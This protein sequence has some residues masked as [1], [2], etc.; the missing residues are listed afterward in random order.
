MSWF[1]PIAT[2]AGVIITALAAIWVAIIQ[3]RATPYDALSNRVMKLEASDAEKGDL[4][5]SQT[6]RLRM[7]EEDTHMLVDALT[8]Q[9]D[10]QEAGA[11]PPP[12]RIERRVLE[13]LRRHRAERRRLDQLD[14]QTT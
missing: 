8:E 2:V 14:A 7:L 6:R 11:D 9:E 12:P 3:R 13:I 4:I 1:G 5:Q 10:W